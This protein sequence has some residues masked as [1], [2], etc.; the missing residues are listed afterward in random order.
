MGLSAYEITVP[1]FIRSLTA[2]RGLLS[3]A[4]EYAE[5]KKIQPEVLLETRLAPDQFPLGRQIQIACDN[6]KGCVARLSNTDA[7]VFEDNEQ[8]LAEFTT[9]IDKTIEYIK[10]FKAEQFGNFDQCTVRFPWYPGKHM[11]GRTYLVQHA[12]PNFYFHM[13]T[14]YSIL[15][16]NGVELGKGDFL[17]AQDWKKD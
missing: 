13:T 8:T 12:I 5:K 11:D 4:S 9:R 3:K 7:P 2:M 1:Q 14:A 16:A 10:K 15:R 6:A 17:G